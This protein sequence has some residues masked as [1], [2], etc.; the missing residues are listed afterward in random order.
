MA[1]RNSDSWILPIAGVGGS[2]G[3]DLTYIGRT[4]TRAQIAMTIARGKDGMAAFATL[5]GKDLESLLD[6]LQSLK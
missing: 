5:S 1:Q 3:P 4:L 6:Y 2:V